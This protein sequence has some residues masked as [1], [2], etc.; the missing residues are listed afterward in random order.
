MMAAI[1][2]TPQLKQNPGHLRISLCTGFH[3][4]NLRCVSFSLHSKGLISKSTVCAPHLAVICPL[5]LCIHI[6][7]PSP[8]SCAALNNTWKSSCHLFLARPCFQSPVCDRQNSGWPITASF[9]H[10]SH[11]WLAIGCAH[12]HFRLRCCVTQSSMPKLSNLSLC[13]VCDSLN[14]LQPVVDAFFFVVFVVVVHVFGIV[15]VAKIC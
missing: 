14:P 2:L 7:L 1:L 6:H 11:V 9:V 3:S 4:N 8:S 15:V 12:F 10:R 5:K 13:F